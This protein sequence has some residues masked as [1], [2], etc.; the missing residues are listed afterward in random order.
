MSI[1]IEIRYLNIDPS[2]SC[3]AKKLEELVLILIL[4]VI[5][6]AVEIAIWS[7]TGLLTVV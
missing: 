2:N 4:V 5:I 7:T 6:N 1:A 3:V